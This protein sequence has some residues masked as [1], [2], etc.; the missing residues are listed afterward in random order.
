MKYFERFMVTASGIVFRGDV[1]D[2][3]DGIATAIFIGYPWEI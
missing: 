3:Y 2:G 1:A